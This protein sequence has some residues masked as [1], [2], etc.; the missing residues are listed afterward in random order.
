MGLGA[1]A[2]DDAGALG[3]VVAASA[4]STLASGAAGAFV[5]RRQP[6]TANTAIKSARRTLVL[7]RGLRRQS[8][9]APSFFPRAHVRG[10]VVIARDFG[11]GSRVLGLPTKGQRLHR[12]TECV[13]HAGFVAR[14]R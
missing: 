2:A 10:R 1:E 5:E 13:E 14:Q 7:G 11:R 9:A 12:S 6:S 3:G 8:F 4:G